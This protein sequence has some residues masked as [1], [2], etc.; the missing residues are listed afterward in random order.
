MDITTGTHHFQI[1]RSESLHIVL[2]LCCLVLST[3]AHKSLECPKLGEF[4][5]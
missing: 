4:V 5:F 3:D 2:K 1:L